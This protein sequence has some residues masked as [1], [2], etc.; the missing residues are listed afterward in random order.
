MKVLPLEGGIQVA[1]RKINHP[2]TDY[3]NTFWRFDAGA[4]SRFSFVER[5]EA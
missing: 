4:F 5:R 1:F 2:H 3:A